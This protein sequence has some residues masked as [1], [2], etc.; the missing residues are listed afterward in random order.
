MTPTTEKKGEYRSETKHIKF[1]AI[2]FVLHFSRLIT[3][4]T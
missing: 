4:N 1:L 2:M 3:V